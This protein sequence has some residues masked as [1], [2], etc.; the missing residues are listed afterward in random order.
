LKYRNDHVE[1]SGNF[2]HGGSSSYFGTIQE[3][4]LKC[5]VGAQYSKF[6]SDRRKKKKLLMLILLSIVSRKDF[7]KLSKSFSPKN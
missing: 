1:H 3:R 5:K 6:I 7:R 4:A 2:G